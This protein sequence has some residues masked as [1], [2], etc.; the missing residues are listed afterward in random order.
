MTF[1]VPR[2][3]ERESAAWLGL[4]TVTQLLPNALDSQ[5]QR[6]AGL[7]H[8]EF[9]VLTALQLA[10]GGTLRMTALAEATVSTL[11]RLSHVCAR[12]ERR[13]LVERF[14]CAQDRRAT[15]VRLT[16]DGRRSLVRA[17]PD[18]LATARRVV[19]DALRP[20]QLVALA[21]ITSVIRERLGGGPQCDRTPAVAAGCDE[22]SPA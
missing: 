13:G 7:T 10:P 21:E 16:G 14:S 11:P 8:F 19:I 6:D 3:D 5:L 20:D 2:M 22:S 17:I 1:Q 18:H 15:N 4:V 9:T 12:L